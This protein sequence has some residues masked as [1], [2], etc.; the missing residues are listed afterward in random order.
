MNSKS[1]ITILKYLLSSCFKPKVGVL[2]AP[3]CK[4]LHWGPI[5]FLI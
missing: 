3:E 5:V 2:A 1:I 4:W